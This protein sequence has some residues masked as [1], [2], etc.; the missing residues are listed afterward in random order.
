MVF[1]YCSELSGLYKSTAR[2][3]LKIY[4]FEHISEQSELSW[5]GLLNEYFYQRVCYWLAFHYSNW[6]GNPIKTPEITRR[7]MIGRPIRHAETQFSNTKRSSIFY[8][9]V[10]DVQY[11]CRAF[12]NLTPKRDKNS[13]LKKVSIVWYDCM[14]ELQI[15]NTTQHKRILLDVVSCVKEHVQIILVQD[16]LVPC[17]N[18]FGTEVVII[19]VGGQK[20]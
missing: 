18:H 1:Y 11:Y 7:P 2:L 15:Q 10:V 4:V 5:Y 6:I 8:E 17:T 13:L 20:M 3:L 14:L 12:G 9:Y 19:I 16:R